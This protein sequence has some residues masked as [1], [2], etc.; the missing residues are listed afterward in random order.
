MPIDESK[1]RERW[2]RNKRADR[3]RRKGEPI[4]ITRLFRRRVMWARNRRAKS[5]PAGAWTWNIETRYLTGDKLKRAVELVADVWAAETLH[6]VQWGKGTATVAHICRMLNDMDRT[7][8]YS[9]ASL[10]KMV[11]KARKRVTALETHGDP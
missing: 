7:H 3:A 1:R 11:A 10:P 9:T 8:G 5:A 2:L 6:D 4:P